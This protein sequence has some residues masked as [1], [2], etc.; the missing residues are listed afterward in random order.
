MEQ[1]ASVT[2]S[3]VGGRRFPLAWA[4]TVAN[5]LIEILKP[6]CVRIVWAGSI[7]RRRET[8]K[9]IEIV[10]IPAT[11]AV[12][13]LFGQ[14]GGHSLN[15][16]D[17]LLER[18]LA[19]RT[20]E[21]YRNGDAH[22]AWGPRFKKILFQGFPVDLF[23]VLPPAQFGL[24]YLIRTGPAGFSHRLVTHRRQGG[25][26]PEWLTVRDGALRGKDGSSVETP[27]EE[28]VFQLLKI[29]YLPPEKRA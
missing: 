16:L 25:L 12:T 9:D 13:D 21:R 3:G 23:T 11:V 17:E 19:D 18:L 29:P 7:R 20:L 15:K 4:E 26:L 1:Q 28:D 8:V 5:E 6:A 2:E 14:P 22:G 27:E 10:A 24:I